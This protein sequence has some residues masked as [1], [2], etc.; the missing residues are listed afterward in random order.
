MGKSMMDK[1]RGKPTQRKNSSDWMAGL[2]NVY[3]SGHTLKMAH[4]D[5]MSSPVLHKKKGR[6]GANFSRY[7]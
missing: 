3:R 1:D 4:P 5:H 7:A 2:S 6:K